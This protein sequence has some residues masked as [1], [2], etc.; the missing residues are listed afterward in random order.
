MKRGSPTRSPNVRVSL[1]GK[2]DGQEWEK[3]GIPS[4][5]K[6]KLERKRVNDF[7]I[8]LRVAE[9]SEN[10]I[11]AKRPVEEKEKTKDQC[12]KKLESEFQFRKPLRKNLG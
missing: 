10:T 3:R 12:G 11:A 6:K 1:V 8:L 5:R 9:G 4:Y 7:L 2:A